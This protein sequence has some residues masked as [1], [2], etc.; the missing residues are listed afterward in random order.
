MSFPNFVG[1]HA[2]DAMVNPQDMLAYFRRIGTVTTL[3]IPESFILCY[4]RRMAAPAAL[5]RG[6]LLLEGMPS[7]C[8][9]V[10]SAS[11][12]IGVCMGF[13]IGA[14]AATSMLEM[15]IALGA[16]RF[17]SIGTA[18]TLQ[19]QCAVGSIV[20]CDRAIRDEGV[21]HHYLPP[22]PY[23]TPSPTLTTTFSAALA[24]QNLTTI[25]GTT[26]TI[27]APYR[28]TIEES[29]H[30]QQAGVLSVEME[31]AALFAVAQ[32]RGVA[33]ASGFVISD[34]LADLVWEPQFQSHAV[35]EGYASLFRAAC[36]ALSG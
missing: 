13:G 23:A 22:A 8:Y 10:P 35:A 28:E 26:W 5:E 21:S 32:V 24:A 3:P 33:I 15:L 7:T 29:R 20:V 2:H 4:H 34:S 17:M 14:P 12:P 25:T 31:A 19:P 18:G 11:G 27:D 30:Y 16:R 1:K 36:D 9:T 6:G